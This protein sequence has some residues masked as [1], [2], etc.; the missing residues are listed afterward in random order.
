MDMSGACWHCPT[1]WW[2]NATFGALSLGLLGIALML[3][4]SRSGR[5]RA[6]GGLLF[7]PVAFLYLITTVTTLRYGVN[8]SG[9][10]RQPRLPSLEGAVVGVLY[11]TTAVLVILHL[12]A[13]RNAVARTVV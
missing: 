11:L 8:T 2:I 5:W 9:S 13:K 7:F 10:P 1:P 4:R 12:R 3:L 6:G